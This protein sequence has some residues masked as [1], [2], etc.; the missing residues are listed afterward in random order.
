MEMTR[1]GNQFLRSYG[2]QTHHLSKRTNFWYDW[3]IVFWF[4]FFK[5]LK[6]SPIY[7]LNSDGILNSLKK[8]HSIRS[9]FVNKECL[10]FQLV[11]V[12]SDGKMLVWKMDRKTK[13]IE[14]H[15]GYCI[16]FFFSFKRLTW[17]LNYLFTCF[18]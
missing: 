4:F 15:D 2:Y 8:L 16:F 13:Q 7:F 12:S 3:Y 17:C 10:W 9:N 14:L 1:T 5:L 6:N 18:S 11:S